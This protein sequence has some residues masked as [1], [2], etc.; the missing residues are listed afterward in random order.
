VPCPDPP[1]VAERSVGGRL[2]LEA[3][4][5][6]LVQES[7]ELILSIRA[8]FT[9]FHR[10]CSSARRMTS[11]SAFSTARRVMAL[12]EKPLVV[13]NGSAATAAGSTRFQRGGSPNGAPGGSV[14]EAGSALGESASTV[15]NTARRSMKRVDRP[16]RR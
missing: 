6:D 13:A 8:V 14:E 15:R 11:R 7:A 2:L 3:H 1:Q 10:H 5:L 12:R 4:V 16:A 9:R